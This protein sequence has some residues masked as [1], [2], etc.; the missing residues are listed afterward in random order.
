MDSIGVKKY[1]VVKKSRK[2]EP[3]EGNTFSRAKLVRNRLIS[4]SNPSN[5]IL[6]L[7]TQFDFR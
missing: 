4:K 6:Y 7:P 5:P 3:Q 1:I 2:V